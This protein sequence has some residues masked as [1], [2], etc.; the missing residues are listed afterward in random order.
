MEPDRIKIEQE[1]PNNMIA[2]VG[3]LAISI[4]SKGKRW[5]RIWL[6]TIDA[7]GYANHAINQ[8]WCQLWKTIKFPNMHKN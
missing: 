6:Q 5:K 2:N 4:L 3:S 8:F 7:T 1:N